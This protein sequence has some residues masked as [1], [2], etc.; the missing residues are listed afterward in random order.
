MH[1][2]LYAH[3]DPVTFS[4]PSGQSIVTFA[5]HL[6]LQVSMRMWA[7]GPA[8][9]A[10]AAAVGRAYNALGAT[11]QSG[12]W[13][14]AL[15]FPQLTVSQEQWM[16]ARSRL[17]LV[18]ELGRRV[19]II[20]SK[21]KIPVSGEPLARMTK[22]LSDAL[23]SGKGEVVLFVVKQP[24]AAEMAKVPAGVRVVVGYHDLA[25]WIERFFGIIPQ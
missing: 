14:I 24:T 25:I 11:V 16:T 3:A 13:Q 8:F 10:G 1:N 18:L 5:Y 12:A 2:Y 6:T 7:I 23:A 22:Q 20:E 9:A 21:Y 15:R 4:D 17:D 19:A